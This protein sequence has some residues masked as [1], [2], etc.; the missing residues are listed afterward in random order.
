MSRTTDSVLGDL[1]TVIKVWTENPIF[2]MGDLTLSGVQ[3]KR[4]DLATRDNAVDEARTTLSRLI[5][6]ASDAR[7][8]GAQIV[9]RARS[10]MRSTFGPNS[11]QYAQVG[12]TRLSERK[13]AKRKAGGS[14]G[15]A[16]T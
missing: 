15:G 5:D 10:G 8:E 14:E 4:A 16:P 6:E 3:A 9:T 13:P 12:G 1:D 2:A 7:K 11:T